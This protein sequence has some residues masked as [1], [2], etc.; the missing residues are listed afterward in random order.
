L[1]QLVLESCAAI[2]ACAPASL[3]PFPRDFPVQ[4][5]PR[6]VV[7]R[8]PSPRCIRARHAREH[9]RPLLAEFLDPLKEFCPAQ[10]LDLACVKAAFGDRII[11][12]PRE[13]R[14]QNMVDRFFHVSPYSTG[15]DAGV[16]GGAILAQAAEGIFGRVARGPI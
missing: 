16:N 6:I 10:R 2:I 15:E 4:R 5:Q 13:A 14:A 3:A 7:P 9:R 12:S 8:P 1:R 11:A